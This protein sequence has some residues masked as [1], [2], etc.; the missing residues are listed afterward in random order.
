ML[1]NS[2]AG[3]CIFHVI[4][5]FG[6]GAAIIGGAGIV[7]RSISW[8]SMRRGANPVVIVDGL[9][10]NVPPMNNWERD[11]LKVHKFPLL[12]SIPIGSHSLG[13]TRFRQIHAKV[14]FKK[15]LELIRPNLVHMH[16]YNGSLRFGFELKRLTGA[17]IIV[18]AHGLDTH[19]L[20]WK[21]YHRVE[22]APS[23]KESIEAVDA[24]VPVGPLVNEKLLKWG[25]SEEKIIP[26]YNGVD[27]PDTLAQFKN[28]IELK[29]QAKIVYAGRV[30][31][32]KGVLDL[33]DAVVEFVGLMPNI[34]PHLQIVGGC[35]EEMEHALHDRL[36][37]AK[38]QLDYEL[39]GEVNSERV[40]E[41]VSA[42]DIFCH[43]S[44]NPNEGIGLA[45]LEPG[46][47]GCPMILSDHPAYF[48][49]V[50]KPDIHAVF[51][52]SG[53]VKGLALSIVRLVKD[54]DLRRKLR[55]NA[56]KLVKERYNRS[57]M[58]DDYMALYE[59]LLEGN[60]DR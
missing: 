52:K 50:Y 49:S 3:K 53:N 39:L 30:I 36:K 16:L 32:K 47:Y 20:K 35:S 43:P 4:E 60:R 1:R 24:W 8:E 15:V 11:G 58:L 5:N 31:K 22:Y 2:L 10:K 25:I 42:S 46:A 54:G 27:V 56:Y 41:I 18:T 13:K 48:M 51:H 17:K 19:F 7:L 33:A 9:K 14:K 45:V 59:R 37:N 29:R 34:R 6:P 12:R 44:K 28:D 23:W 21:K 38:G 55:E 40:R 57:K 26:I